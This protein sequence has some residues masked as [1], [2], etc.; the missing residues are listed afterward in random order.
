MQPSRSALLLNVES[1][2]ALCCFKMIFAFYQ[3]E[4]FV[5]LLMNMKFSKLLQFSRIQGRII[6]RL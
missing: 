5:N 1:K 3:E 4:R 6:E 2:V